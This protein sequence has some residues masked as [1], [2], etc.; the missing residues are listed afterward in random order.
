MSSSWVFKTLLLAVMFCI[1]VTQRAPLATPEGLLAV[2]TDA[3]ANSAV[4]GTGRQ[5]GPE[6]QTAAAADAAEGAKVS[7]GTL[8][9]AAGDA[10]PAGSGSGS[11]LEQL[12]ADAGDSTGRLRRLL[13]P[14]PLWRFCFASLQH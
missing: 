8:E 14:L 7:P 6:L 11:D 3:A 10:S 9:V 4:Q 5:A 1:L 13:L 2:G 12:L